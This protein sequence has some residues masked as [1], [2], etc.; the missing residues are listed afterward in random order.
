MDTGPGLTPIPKTKWEEVPLRM[1]LCE[2]CTQ[3]LIVMEFS[4]ILRTA[5][6]ECL[7]QMGKGA[8]EQLQ[9]SHRAPR[10]TTG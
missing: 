4:F 5:F 3:R 6:N 7:G 9:G 1:D 2:P 8:Q 10:T